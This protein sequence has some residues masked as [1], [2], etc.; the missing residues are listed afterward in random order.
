MKVLITGVT[1]YLGSR[2]A[3]HLAGAGYT[4]H[5]LCR[6]RCSWKHSDTNN[7]RIFEGDLTKPSTIDLAIL[8]CT[9]I[10]HA[11]AYTRMNDPYMKKFY[12][13][14]VQG[15]YNL[16]ITAKNHNIEK[17]I[18]ISSLS[19][20]GKSF[21]GVP[22]HEK[23]PRTIA[24]QNHYELT[25]AMAEE[26]VIDFG[27]DSVP[28]LI[29]NVSRLYGPGNYTFSNGVNRF[30]QRIA[31]G[32]CMILPN[33]LHTKANYLYIDDALLAIEKCL[34]PGSP[35]NERLIVG[36][37][38]CDYRNLIRI[39]RE[40][41]GSSLKLICLPYG[42]VRTIIKFIYLVGK[43]LGVHGTFNP[44]LLDSLFT[45]REAMITHARTLLHYNTT[46]LERGIENTLKFMNNEN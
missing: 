30:L 18:F 34:H 33:R 28:Y 3:L 15:T 8:G 23:Q 9:T 39:A 45:E 7:I 26:L 41:S 38:N 25:K 1:G 17:F 10:I 5:G 37:E 43:L 11:A 16:L 24:Y 13:A 19:V 2:L 14:N 44:K 20:L 42:L 36:G 35:L 32:K 21:P 46:G 12:D 40:K 31:K 29:L 4:V 27:K 22:I 6:N